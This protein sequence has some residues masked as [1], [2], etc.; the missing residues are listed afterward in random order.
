MRKSIVILTLLLLGL[1]GTESVYAQTACTVTLR[2]ARTTYD[3]GRLHELPGLLAPCL[4]SG[5][6][7]QEAVEAYKLL[8]LSYIYLEEPTKADEAMLALLRT[9]PYFEVNP[10]ADAA[11]F[12]AL[13]RTFRTWPVFRVGAKAGVNATQPHVT[14]YVDAIEGAQVSY[15]P[16]INFMSGLVFEIPVADRLSLNPEAYFHIRSFSYESDL[17]LTDDLTN[18]SEGKEV[19]TSV[20]VPVSIQYSL[21]KT[22]LNPYVSAGVSVEYLLKSSITMNRLRV[23]ANSIPERTFDATESRKRIL[24]NAVAAAGIKAR[25]GSGFVVTELRLTYGLTNVNDASSAFTLND[26][27]LFD[28][29]YADNSMRLNSLSLTVGYIYNVFHPKKLKPGR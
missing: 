1:A 21:A 22:K 27:L 19:Q 29:G 3:E 17:S 5:F 20:S 16:T 25:L 13:Y 18:T 15:S 9:D 10:S 24:V 26:Y 12:I 11:E 14:A 6:T 8:V 2:T 23:N 28:T 4:K 7:R